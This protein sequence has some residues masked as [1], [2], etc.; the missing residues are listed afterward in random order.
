[1]IFTI[2]HYIITFIAILFLIIIKH[3]N[4]F[5]FLLKILLK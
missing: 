3:F 1:M 2:T 5:I 4:F